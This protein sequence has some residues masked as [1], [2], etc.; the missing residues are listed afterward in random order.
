MIRHCR[1]LPYSLGK[2]VGM[3]AGDFKFATSNWGKTKHDSSGTGDILYLLV[4]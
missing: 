1:H 4:D 2:T 3:S